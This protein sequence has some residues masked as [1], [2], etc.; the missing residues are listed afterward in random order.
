MPIYQII[1]LSDNQYLTE[2]KS[3]TCK[4][5]IFDFNKFARKKYHLEEHEK[6]INSFIPKE[7]INKYKIISIKQYSKRPEIC[8]LR[9]IFCYISRYILGHTFSYIG[10]YLLNRD[11]TS[12]RNAC[13]KCKNLIEKDS[14]FRN[15]Y[16][17][18][19]SKINENIYGNKLLQSTSEES[20]DSKPTLS[21]VLL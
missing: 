20:V 12:I 16:Y 10:I 6:V 4:N 21:T 5:A 2:V 8:D 1:K 11:H 14:M 19:L 3:D 9:H 13:I 7:I 15:K 17:N 18:I